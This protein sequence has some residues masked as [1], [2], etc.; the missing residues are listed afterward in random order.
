[1]KKLFAYLFVIAITVCSCIKQTEPTTIQKQI[2]VQGQDGVEYLE[3]SLSF[4]HAIGNANFIYNN[5]SGKSTNAKRI[6][7]VELLSSD[8]LAH[9]TTTRSGNI[10][11]RNIPLAYV[12][13]YADNQGYAILAADVQ[14][15]P[16]IAVGDSGNFTTDKFLSFVDNETATRT[17]EELNPAEE[18]Q[19]AM[20]NNSLTQFDEHT[21]RSV[22]PRPFPAVDTMMVLKCLP[23]V[24]TK[25]GQRAPYNYY[26]PLDANGNKYLAGCVPV[27]GAQ[28]LASLCYHHNFW[29]TIAIDNEFEV[30]WYEINRMIFEDTYMFNSNDTSSDAL[31]VAKLIRSI[32]KNINA[33]YNTN[34]TTASTSDLVGLYTTLGIQSAQ[35]RSSSDVTKNDLFDMIVRKNLPVNARADDAN[36]TGGHSF[37]LDGWLRLEYSQTGLHPVD[38]GNG[39]TVNYPNNTQ[40]Q[41]DLVHVNFGWNGTCDGYYLP[42]AFDTSSNNF[43]E[44]A[45]ENDNDVIRSYKYNLNINYV[46]YELE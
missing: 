5:I 12:V 40:Y 36:G 43:N 15:P 24:P 3:T 10:D 27:A 19:Y 46:T 30:N 25:W 34:S 37:I 35:I 20:V 16:V 6:K 14:L 29:P 38:M 13:N 8:D 1:M 44:Y 45:E 22:V 31:N 17:N 7:N 4:E 18:L 23:L 11:D 21:T 41:F 9:T 2:D 32:G 33:D 39:F 42:G 26:S 28:V